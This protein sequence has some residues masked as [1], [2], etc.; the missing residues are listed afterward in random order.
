MGSQWI[1]HTAG[2]ASQPQ[3]GAN[4]VKVGAVQRSGK[5]NL[6]K[7]PPITFNRCP[8]AIIGIGV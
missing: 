3:L 5:H 8:V 2:T 7:Y 4:I 1:N 6:Q